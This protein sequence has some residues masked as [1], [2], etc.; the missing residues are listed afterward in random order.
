M[1][2]GKK[3]RFE[4]GVAF[5]ITSYDVSNHLEIA[6]VSHHHQSYQQLASDVDIMASS[7]EKET[8]IAR[9]FLSRTCMT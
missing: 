4:F 8:M 7:F 1:G 3:N 6:T 2:R 9:H 5:G